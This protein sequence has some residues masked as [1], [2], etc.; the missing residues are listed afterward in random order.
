[1]D[2][3]DRDEN[4][5]EDEDEDD[6]P[7][8]GSP[9]PIYKY[10]ANLLSIMPHAPC[11]MQESENRIVS[12]KKEAKPKSQAKEAG[13][14]TSHY[15]ERPAYGN[16]YT[17]TDTDADAEADAVADTAEDGVVYGLMFWRTVSPGN[18]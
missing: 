17:D 2:D 10:S 1:M 12:H 13:T 16:G 4:E 5:D 6:L 9:I 11:P 8:T 3:E 15:V 14:L 18:R 7:L